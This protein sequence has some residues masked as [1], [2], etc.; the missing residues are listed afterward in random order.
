MSWV[1]YKWNF[2]HCEN[3]I[4]DL[5]YLFSSLIHN[6]TPAYH[7]ILEKFRSESKIIT[8]KQWSI[9]LNVLQILLQ[10]FQNVDIVCL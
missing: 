5:L 4:D 10:K 7:R 2:V 8:L 1:V 6:T 9:G 3:L